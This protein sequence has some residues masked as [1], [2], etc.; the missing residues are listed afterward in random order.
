MT[1]YFADKD[2]LKGSLVTTLKEVRPT[3]FFGVPRV[4]EKI[5]ERM[6]A[7]GKANKGLK[8]AVGEWA[9]KTGYQQSKRIIEVSSITW[10]IN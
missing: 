4:Y 2:A 6:T 9:K 7:V 3:Y 1:L 5:M 8:K 10:K